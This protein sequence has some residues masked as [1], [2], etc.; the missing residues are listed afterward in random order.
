MSSNYRIFVEKLGAGIATSF[1]GDRGELFYDPSST[2]L[3]ISDGST[4]GGIIITGAT[5]Q[6][7]NLSGNTLSISNGN[8][9][10]LS[11][12]LKSAELDTQLGI[13]T[14]ITG[15]QT[16]ATWTLPG[17]YTNE[18]AAASAGIQIGQAYY[19]NGG[20]VRVRLT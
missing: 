2:D 5:A 18:A 9:V 10:D 6:T 12:Y 16:G 7:L 1:V 13:S 14:I 17:A 8:S 3:R 19:D 4:P 11:V 15:I 20:T